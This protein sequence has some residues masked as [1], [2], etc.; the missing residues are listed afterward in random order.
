MFGISSKDQLIE[1]ARL[2][3]EKAPDNYK[4]IVELYYFARFFSICF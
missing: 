1:K 2:Q 3:A 4:S